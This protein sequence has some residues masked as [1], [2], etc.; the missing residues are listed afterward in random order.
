MVTRLEL[1]L[2]VACPTDQQPPRTYLKVSTQVH[3][4]KGENFNHVTFS[5]SAD[6]TMRYRLQHCMHVY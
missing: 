3:V 2:H 4:Q 1:Y 5:W 6:L